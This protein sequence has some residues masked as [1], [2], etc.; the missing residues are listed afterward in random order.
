ML[1][2]VDGDVQGISVA[3]DATIT[4][5]DWQY[6]TASDTNWYAVGSVTETAALLLDLDTRLRF[7]PALNFN[8][9]VPELKV[10]GMDSFSGS[11]VTTGSLRVF[12]D[13]TTRGGSTSFSADAA[14]INSSVLAVIDSP[15]TTDSTISAVSYTHLTLPTILL[16]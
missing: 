14:V 5:G 15:E 11:S 7:V 12:S 16:V 6:S 9:A 3:N 10:Y 2:D 8:G 1:T 4:E 13:V